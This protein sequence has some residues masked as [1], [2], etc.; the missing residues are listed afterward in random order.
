MRKWRAIRYALAG[1]LIY[2]LFCLPSVLFNDPLSKVMVD[3]KG[4]FLEARIAADDQ[5]RFPPIDSVPLAFKQCITAFE[6]QYFDYHPGFNPV[7][8][9]RAIYL[10][11]KHGR[12]VSGGSTITMQ[13]IRLIR[14]KKN[15]TPW[16]KFI[17]ITWALRLETK[18]SKAQILELYTNNA[19][20]GGNV[21]GL[22]TAAWRYFNRPPEELSWAEN[23]T[24]AVLPNSP[25]LIHMNR[26]RE[27]LIIKRNKL[28]FSLNQK[29]IISD[30]SYS[31]AIAETLPDPINKLP[32]HAFHLIDRFK[33]QGRIK[34]TLD[35]TI[36]RRFNEACYQYGSIMAQQQVYNLSAV[37][38]DV[39]S[40]DVVAYVG[41]IHMNNNE[42]SGKVDMLRSVRSSG[43]ILKPI[44]YTGAIDQSLITPFEVL[45]DYPINFYGYRPENYTQKFSGLVP[46]NEAL[47]RSLNVPA[48]WLLSRYG[49][50][51]MKRD[52]QQLGISTLKLPASHYG[53]SMVLGG[54]EINLLELTSA[55]A[56]FASA[57]NAGSDSSTTYKTYIKRPKEETTSNNPFSTGSIYSTLSTLTNTY[58]PE[59][60]AHWRT[61]SSKERI[62]WKTG[63][64]FGNRDAWAVGVTP[65]YAIGVW[66]GNSE[67]EGVSG[68]TGL[69]NA[70]PLLFQ[71]FDL[72]PDTLWFEEPRDIMNIE[73][74]TSSGMKC[75][76]YCEPGTF[77]LMPRSSIKRIHCTYHQSVLLERS[78]RQRVYRNCAMGEVYM[79]TFFVLSPIISHYYAQINPS[80]T[81]LPQWSSDCS[82]GEQSIEVLYPVNGSR[83]SLPKEE[84]YE[85]TAKAFF[86]NTEDRLFWDLNGEL[87][88]STREIH[89]AILKPR[90]GKNILVI[91]DSYGNRR[92]VIFY[93]KD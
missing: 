24:L 30:A 48:A 86:A 62:A 37:L 40:G 17:E 55:Y 41:N 50:T 7:S 60:E 21:I 80:Y 66:V 68:L 9:F 59:A 88:Y 34:T 14:K 61:F 6:D 71:L 33:D 27:E 18:Y 11:V 63:T 75:G 43:S 93:V 52:L 57:L 91:S 1:Y 12:I 83:L 15:R 51:H 4:E 16:E 49:T 77:K 39:P 47:Y 31:V 36:Q 2:F 35:A 82:S 54:A 72:I 13:T 76:P 28:L 42:H 64:S 5:W 81:L 73:T 19:P 79:D 56:C 22:E 32:H 23:A 78:T 87:V 26:N 44:L 58:R 74:C 65:K 3:R 29:K 85:I 89:S 92:E 70:A 67:G 69:N 25:G 20:F 53:L 8:L 45:P 10:N 90:K 46:A 38:L 84:G